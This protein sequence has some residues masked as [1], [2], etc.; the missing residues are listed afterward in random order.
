MNAQPPASKFSQ[1]ARRK[2]LMAVGSS[3]PQLGALL[4]SHVRDAR[5]GPFPV[6]KEGRCA[7]V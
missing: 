5:K 1:G 2:T 6:Q 4:T 7:A 3:A